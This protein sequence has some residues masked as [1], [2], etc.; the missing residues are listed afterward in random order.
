MQTHSFSSVQTQYYQCPDLNVSGKCGELKDIFH[1][2]FQFLAITSTQ[3]LVFY[4][5]VLFTLV[6]YFPQRTS[7][8]CPL[9]VP[10]SEFLL[11]T[12]PPR[13][14]ALH[15]LHF[16]TLAHVSEPSAAA[17]KQL[18]EKKTHAPHQNFASKYTFTQNEPLWFSRR[19]CSHLWCLAK[20]KKYL[21]NLVLI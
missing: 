13:N 20:N 15:L 18:W 12:S 10:P 17:G 1:L 3:S 14:H 11:L 5:H 6:L 19:S 16:T 4:H 2:E 9:P 8:W 7:S 21:L